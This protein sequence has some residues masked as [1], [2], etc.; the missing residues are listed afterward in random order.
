MSVPAPQKLRPLT[1]VVL[2]GTYFKAWLTGTDHLQETSTRIICSSLRE[3]L[4]FT[5][6]L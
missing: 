1:A 2:V 6:G 3:F 5:D 4:Y